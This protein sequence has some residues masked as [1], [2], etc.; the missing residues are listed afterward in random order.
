MPDDYEGI[1]V[2]GAPR[3]GT[4]LTQRLLAAHPQIACPPETYLLRACSR[5]L[6]EEKTVPS[7]A[8][9]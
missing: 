8:A 4:T 3:S 6:H 7:V 5:F 9:V 1:I 2:L